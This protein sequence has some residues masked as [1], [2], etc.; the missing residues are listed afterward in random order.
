MNQRHAALPSAFPPW[1]TFINWD[2][3]QA[4]GLLAVWSPIASRGLP[5]L[6]EL[7]SGRDGE[8]V[9]GASI[10]T[11]SR[12]LAALSCN[13]STDY[14]DTNSPFDDLKA[15]NAMTASAWCYNT[16][17][18][19]DGAVISQFGT[20]GEEESFLLW[21][22][23]GDVDGYAAILNDG[24]L[25]R[26]G[27]AVASAVQNQWQH[28]AL[29]WNGNRLTVYVDGRERDHAD[30]TGTLYAASPDVSIG[31]NLSSGALKPWP[32][33][34][35]DVRLNAACL[36]PAIIWQMWDPVT[37][38]DLVLP[39]TRWW[40]TPEMVPTVTPYSFIL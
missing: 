17:L 22:D 37:R 6:R 39:V 7:I 40:V 28:V 33:Y 36:S 1:P 19:V 26:C 4:A 10:A 13:G 21:M 11:V 8:L 9:A 24:T 25:V 15:N 5:H 27:E 20:A 18:T 29:T 14:V 3:P 32:G 38:W 23:T 31:G 2:S 12:F 16:N 34:I 30:H 35:T